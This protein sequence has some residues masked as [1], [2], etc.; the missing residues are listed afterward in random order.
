MDNHLPP[1]MADGLQPFQYLPLDT[2][3]PLT[4]QPSPPPPAGPLAKLHSALKK[5]GLVGSVVSLRS[6]EHGCKCIGCSRQHLLECYPVIGRDVCLCSFC[7]ALAKSSRLMSSAFKKGPSRDQPSQSPLPPR[8]RG[9]PTEERCIWCN[10]TDD[11][12][13]LSFCEKEAGPMCPPCKASCKRGT[14]K[15]DAKKRC[16]KSRGDWLGIDERI[17]THSGGTCTTCK[18]DA[19]M[20]MPTFDGPLCAPCFTTWTKNGNKLPPPP[21]SPVRVPRQTIIPR[22]APPALK[23]PC[24]TIQCSKCFAACLWSSSSP[25]PAAFM[26]SS[27]AN[28]DSSDAPK[29]CF[30]CQGSVNPI[31]ETFPAPLCSSC[32]L[33]RK[34]ARFDRAHGIVCMWC[35]DNKYLNRVPDGFLCT[36][37]S[38]LKFNGHTKYTF[39]TDPTRRMHPAHIRGLEY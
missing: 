20:L 11:E 1:I 21:S 36:S 19:A 7:A 33:R 17:S 3:S 18:Y 34:E 31:V 4:E 15:E 30:T 28:R 13:K 6:K 35:D 16:R 38:A 29:K 39:K 8:K 10:A 23:R 24:V 9:V 26:C 27:C 2:V 25:P 37:C 5:N 32:E 22:P 12:Y 14:K